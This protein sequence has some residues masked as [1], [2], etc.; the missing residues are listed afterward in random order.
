MDMTIVVNLLFSAMHRLTVTSVT[1]VIL[2]ISFSFRYHFVFLFDDLVLLAPGDSLQIFLKYASFRNA[3]VSKSSIYRGPEL[4]DNR[5]SRR[6]EQDPGWKVGQLSEH[7]YAE[8]PSSPT[9]FPEHWNEVFFPQE[10][11]GRI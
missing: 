10:R 3:F 8:Q 11:N 4:R 1:L 6:W 7:L 5:Q 2:W 9:R